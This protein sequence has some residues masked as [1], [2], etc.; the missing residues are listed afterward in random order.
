MT[1]RRIVWAVV[2]LVA[3]LLLYAWIDGGEEPIRSIAEPI[4]LPETAE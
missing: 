4:D 3:A 2:M 1:G